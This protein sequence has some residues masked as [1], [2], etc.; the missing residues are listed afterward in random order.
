MDTEALMQLAV[1]ARQ[2]IETA[3]KTRAH[4]I[5]FERF[6]RAAC[7]ATAEVL[8]RYLRD[9]YGLDAQYVCGH[10]PGHQTHAW[11]EVDGTIIDIT[12]DQFGMDPV[13][14]STESSW[15]SE[16]RKEPPRF[17]KPVIEGSMLSA[18]HEGMKDRGN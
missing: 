1:E 7:G 13:I 12:A 16:W 4:G 5:G 15:H 11:V 8:G 9:A 17:P 2:V 14:V 10:K 3:A 6:P 18:L